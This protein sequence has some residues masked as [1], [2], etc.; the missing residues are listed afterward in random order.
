MIAQGKTVADVCRAIDVTQPS[1]HR[2]KQKY[3]DMQ[4]EEAIRLPA[5]SRS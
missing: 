4:A 2:Q 1:L 3:G 5:S